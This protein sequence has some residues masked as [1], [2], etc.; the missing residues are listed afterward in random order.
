MSEYPPNNA[1][2]AAAPPYEPQPPP[3]TED[4]VPPT[5]ATGSIS[6]SIPFYVRLEWMNALSIYEVSLVMS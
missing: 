6:I 3:Y 5:S 1:G 4:P 2:A